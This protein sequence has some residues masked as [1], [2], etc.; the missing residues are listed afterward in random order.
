MLTL[1]R[2]NSF[3]FYFSSISHLI[4]C[5]DLLNNPF[6]NDLSLN[7]SFGH[8][9]VISLRLGFRRNFLCIFILISFQGLSKVFWKFL[10]RKEIRMK[11][12]TDR[13]FLR[14]PNL[15]A[16]PIIDPNIEKFKRFITLNTKRK[17]KS[18]GLSVLINADFCN[19]TK[20]ILNGNI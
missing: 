4:A 9:N 12:H 13:K 16:H 2:F 10:I 17:L 6:C 1:P 7:L 11:I 20:Y 15:N 19:L 14:N 8:L 18:H 3:Y 5:T